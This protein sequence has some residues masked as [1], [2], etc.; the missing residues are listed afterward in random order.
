MLKLRHAAILLAMFVL[1]GVSVGGIFAAM[2]GG[3]EV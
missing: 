3:G 2:H 1:G